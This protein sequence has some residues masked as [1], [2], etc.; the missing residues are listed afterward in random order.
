MSRKLLVVAPALAC[1][2]VVLFV[3]VDQ[4]L[5][6]EKP[7]AKQAIEAAG[8]LDR[9]ND[10]FADEKPS[11]EKRIE[12]ALNEP[13]T[14]EFVDAPLSDVVEHLAGLHKIEIQID[15]RALDDVGLGTDTSVTRNVKGVSLRS[16]LNLMLHDLQVTY[17]L[18]DEVLLIT[19]P[20]EAANRLLTK[21]YDVADLVTMTYR[22]KTGKQWEEVDF[23]TLIEMI[24]TTVAPQ[25]WEEVGGVGCISPGTFGSAKVIVISQTYQ[26]Q[27]E[28]AKLL[29]E[30]RKIAANSP[31]REPPLRKQ[32]SDTD[33]RGM[34]MGG[35][36]ARRHGRRHG[37]RH[38]RRNGRH[39][40][41][42][43]RSQAG[44][45]EETRGEI[46]AQEEGQLSGTSEKASP[47]RVKPTKRPKASAGCHACFRREGVREWK[48]RNN[49]YL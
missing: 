21:V 10:P 17:T 31:K 1:A 18:R 14:M 37:R 45:Q 42:W 36:H 23:N 9:V 2:A 25:A 22:D 27:R 33:S 32:P 39:V 46:E 26:V 28:I 20:E 16:A 4:S 24:T 7:S 47:H 30:L 13:T 19:T 29:S 48:T 11:A 12:R 5:A 34:G 15:Q 40:L 3:A 38:A 41:W 43:G 8:L 49:T 6:K 44:G 35:W